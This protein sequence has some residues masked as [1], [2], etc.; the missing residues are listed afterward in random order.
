MLQ[1]K[2]ERG[3]TQDCIFQTQEILYFN[4]QRQ[5]VVEKK[6]K[7]KVLA[8]FGQGK[9]KRLSDS[10]KAPQQKGSVNLDLPNGGIKF[11]AL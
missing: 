6:K 9:A 8:L 11:Q 7:G 4:R 1:I 10:P 5:G 2:Y 3:T